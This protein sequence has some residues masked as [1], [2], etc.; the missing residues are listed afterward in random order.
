MI[1]ISPES[2]ELLLKIL[3][4]HAPHLIER[5]FD[6]S[7]CEYTDYSKKDYIALT[8]A[9]ADEFHSA[10][11]REDDEPN[12]YGL[13]CEEL[14][15]EINAFVLL[16]ERPPMTGVQRIRDRVD[17]TAFY[18]ATNAGM[19]DGTVTFTDLCGDCLRVGVDVTG[20]IGK[21]RVE[22]IFRGVRD[23]HLSEGDHIF[24][25]N[26]AFVDGGVIWADAQSFDVEILKQ[27]RYVRAES[28][29][30]LM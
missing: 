1:H 3:K 7:L 24:A 18:E 17:I 9:V 2:N 21:P 6:K 29:E 22:L 28:M 25:S 26:I 27:S 15:D 13:R 16:L 23:W 11:L 14:I 10:G 12:E 8:L 30:W 20:I 5:T 19:H 4:K